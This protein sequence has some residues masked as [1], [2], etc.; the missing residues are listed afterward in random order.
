MNTC[1]F[2]SIVAR[3]ESAVVVHESA[4]F[5][6]F[7][8][9]LREVPGHTIIASK[10]HYESMLDAPTSVG[11]DFVGACQHLANYYRQSSNAVAFNLLSA[12]DDA[13]QQSVM[14]W[15]FHFLPRH[16]NDSISAW[17]SLSGV[18]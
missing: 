13:A 10:S 16:S 11:S 4:E 15:H 2:C 9:L 8:P 6:C 7:L 5:I 1:V 14:H 18:S 3:E 17:P 12:N